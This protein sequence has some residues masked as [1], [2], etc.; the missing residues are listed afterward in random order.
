LD[1][2]QDGS[3]HTF[4]ETYNII[5]GT[6]TSSGTTPADPTTAM[7]WGQVGF[8]WDTTDTFIEQDGYTLHI[9][10]YEQ[11]CTWNDT[12]F[13]LKMRKELIDDTEYDNGVL[14][15]KTHKIQRH[16]IVI[17]MV[18]NDAPSAA[19]DP[20]SALPI[21]FGLEQN[22]PN[23]FNPITQM[24]VRIAE[25]GMVKLS[26]CDMLGREVTVLANEER[27]PGSYT[28]TWDATNMPSGVYFYTLT[29]GGFRETKRMVV[30]K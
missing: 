7:N 24:G 14:T 16:S 8:V 29:A 22:Y 9:T 3:S 15:E 30:L 5:E 11:K 6:K 23:P 18:Y 17:E 4:E 10:H 20:G 26:V 27:S 21:S 12:I 25:F 13:V 2:T 1:A 19:E 28:F